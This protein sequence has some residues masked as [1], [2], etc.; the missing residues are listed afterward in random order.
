VEL[1]PARVPTRRQLL[2]HTEMHNIQI[3]QDLKLAE[4]AVRQQSFVYFDDVTESQPA[5][6][7]CLA[8]QAK[9]GPVCEPEVAAVREALNALYHSTNGYWWKNNTNWR[10]A[11]NY[12]TWASL[13]CDNKGILRSLHMDDYM[14]TD[15]YNATLAPEL[16]N[17]TTLYE[18]SM[19]CDYLT[20]SL[21][22]GFEQMK[23]LQLLDLHGNSFVGL[24]PHGLANLKSL[25][26]IDLTY[27]QLD[28]NIIGDGWNFVDGQPAMPWS[29][30]GQLTVVTGQGRITRPNN[31]L[32]NMKSFHQSG[33]DGT[34]A[35][36]YP[37][38]NGTVPG[39][40][41]QVPIDDIRNSYADKSP[42]SDHNNQP[43]PNSLNS[44]QTASY[45]AMRPL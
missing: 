14:I 8:L 42:A 18:L 2:D 7:E 44:E 36:T 13:G 9:G 30:W 28:K 24:M 26:Y 1:D 33:R 4:M 25:L 41:G 15:W 17:I 5:S 3:L 45:N 19:A 34:W 20:G 16:T 21:P 37:L 32:W 43:I 31:V 6:E 38:T 40:G 10:T 29:S 23:E 39:I 11:N 35:Q 12:C 27:N 22:N